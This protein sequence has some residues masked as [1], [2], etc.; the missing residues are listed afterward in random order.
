MRGGENTV[1]VSPKLR[2]LAQEATRGLTDR[3][4]MELTGLTRTTLR[5]IVGGEVTSMGKLIQFANGL[6]LDATPFI[7]AATEVHGP[8]DPFETIGLVLDHELHLEPR[9][10]LEIQ[11]FIREIVERREASASSEAA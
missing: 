3:Q 5:R 11:R 4:T 7:N 2:D 10:C 8:Y 6:Q 1:A 9:E